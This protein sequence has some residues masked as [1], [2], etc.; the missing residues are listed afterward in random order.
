MDSWKCLKFT[1]KK[2][3]GPE[4]G[5]EVRAAESSMTD[6]MVQVP[7]LAVWG[8]CQAQVC[9]CL[10]PWEGNGEEGVVAWPYSLEVDFSLCLSLTRA[11]AP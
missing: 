11:Y 9:A 4:D 8:I 1:L 10:E 6:C 3:V 7:Y 5:A 2:Y